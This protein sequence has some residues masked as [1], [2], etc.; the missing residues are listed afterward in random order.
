LPI[1][2]K[3]RTSVRAFAFVDIFA[4]TVR[5][6]GVAEIAEFDFR[7]KLST[8]W[9]L[10]GPKPCESERFRAHNGCRFVRKRIKCPK[11]DQ[12]GP[13]EEGSDSMAFWR[14]SPRQD[15]KSTRLN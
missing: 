2:Q 11:A 3:A 8:G 15:R 6:S 7:R 12:S 1:F 5:S 14:R 13:A 9:A 4:V 10:D